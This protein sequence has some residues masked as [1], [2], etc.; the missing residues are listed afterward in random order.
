MTMFIPFI[1]EASPSFGAW[2][3]LLRFL[4]GWFKGKSVFHIRS[5]HVDPGSYLLCFSE[6]VNQGQPCASYENQV[7]ATHLLKK[8]S[9]N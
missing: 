5:E 9:C 6:T 7:Q 4:S 3:L 2:A 1:G 8:T